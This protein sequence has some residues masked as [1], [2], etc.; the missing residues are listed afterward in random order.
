MIIDELRHL[1]ASI[2]KQSVIVLHV[3]L[4]GLY[5][6]SIG[7]EHDALSLL[8]EIRK[9]LEPKEIYVPTF[10]YTFTKSKVF[11]VRDTPSEVGRFS[12]E[13][14]IN[15]ELGVKRTMDP[16]FS[17]VETEGD[18][19]KDMSLITNPFGEKSI[20][21]YLD[22]ESHHILNINLPTDIV[23]AQIHHFEYINNASYQYLK[24]FEGEVV[25]WLGEKH[26]V[27]YDYFVRDLSKDIK[28]NRKKIADLARSNG[29]MVETSSIRSFDWQ[30]LKKSLINEL[31]T[32]SKY[33]IT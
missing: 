13:I 4:R 7:Y 21:H 1:A 19:L 14:R 30:I 12:E 22:N 6:K 28:W 26:F 18:G 33:L 8:D 25:D 29:G 16:V 23:S 32:D 24:N 27:N 5:D 31:L 17:V 10:T 15:P 11:D 9:Q 3:G 20:W 2:P